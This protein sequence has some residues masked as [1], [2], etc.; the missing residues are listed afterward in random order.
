[1]RVGW[2]KRV[3]TGSG[4]A[5]PLEDPPRLRSCRLQRVYVLADGESREY[6]AISEA[7]KMAR[8]LDL[9]VNNQ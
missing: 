3:S 5:L 8:N 4:L 7:G 2:K 9:S 1:M 6:I